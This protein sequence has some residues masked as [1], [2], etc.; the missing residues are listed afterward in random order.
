MASPPSEVHNTFS[1]AMSSQRKDTVTPAATK[2]LKKDPTSPSKSPLPITMEDIMEELKILKPFVIETNAT[3][4]RLEEKW[5]TLDSRVTEVEQRLSDTQDVIP[6]VAAM[7]K[8]ISLL[9][10]QTE[11]LENRNRRNNLRIYGIPEGEEGSDML[12]FLKLHIPKI[13]GLNG[14]ID[15]NLQRAHR[16]GPIS[17]STSSSSAGSRPRGIIVLFL[18]YT[19]LM[20]VL[21]A[22][23]LRKQML[24]SGQKVFFS[25]DV[26]RAT[27][28]R[29][30][31]FLSF[32]PALRLMNAR[33][34]LVHPCFFKV[35]HKDRTYSFDRP[36]DL[37]QFISRHRG[38]EMD[39]G[40]S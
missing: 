1:T 16:I 27:A 38:E 34:G 20:T 2:R 8:E 17:S 12:A 5:S 4:Q 26:A 35:T 15:L 9:K 32:R 7:S 13:V 19:Q 33:Y 29:R 37:R 18:E 36:E 14:S 23:K 24:W 10:A 39:S 40:G 31:E 11:E 3:L 6:Q 22:A 28:A 30:K 21:S 25:Q